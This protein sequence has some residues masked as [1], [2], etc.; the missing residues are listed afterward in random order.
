LALLVKTVVS[1][2]GAVFLPDG[3]V[4]VGFPYAPSLSPNENPY[5]ARRRV[6]VLDLL[7]GGQRVP[8]PPLWRCDEDDISRWTN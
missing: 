2:V 4:E 3:T 6:G 1:P 7:Q 8:L 5:L